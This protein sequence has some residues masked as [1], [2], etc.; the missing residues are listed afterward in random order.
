MSGGVAEALVAKMMARGRVQIDAI[1]A[2]DAGEW[3]VCWR[4]VKLFE[5]HAALLAEVDRW[6]RNNM[7]EVKAG[8]IVAIETANNG[9]PVFIDSAGRKFT[10]P[11][12]RFDWRPLE[13]PVKSALVAPKSKWRRTAVAA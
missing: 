13:E 2:A 4:S 5:L 1:V 8:P 11:R 9:D 10:A 6:T 3:L 12:G 7:T